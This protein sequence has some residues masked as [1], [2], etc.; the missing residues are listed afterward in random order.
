M[1]KPIVAFSRLIGWVDHGESGITATLAGVRN[2]P[3]QP[4]DSSAVA[5]TSRVVRMSF[6][7]DGFIDV[8]ETQNSVYRR[9]P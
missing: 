2:H 7:S 9:N 6:D 5:S 3:Q 8:I 4:A 1:N